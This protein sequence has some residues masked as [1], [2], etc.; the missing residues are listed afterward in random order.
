MVL[1]VIPNTDN[2][3]PHDL[4]R[5]NM[6]IFLRNYMLHMCPN[7]LNWIEIRRVWGVLMAL[8]SKLLPDRN[9]HLLVSRSIVFHDNWLFHIFEGLLPELLKWSCQ[10]LV[11]I[12]GGVHLLSVLQ[13]KKQTWSHSTP[14]KCPPEHHPS[15]GCTFSVIDIIS[16][17]RPFSIPNPWYSFASPL[18]HSSHLSK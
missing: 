9:A 12:D 11:S 14:S 17:R 16:P 10:D 15:T 18:S 5:R 7:V 6:S 13:F 1:K 3:L 4:L 2:H 8:H